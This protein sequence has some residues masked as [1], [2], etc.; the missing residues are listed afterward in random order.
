MLSSVLGLLAPILKNLF[1]KLL[2]ENFIK[3]VAIQAL[4]GAAKSSNN[5]INEELV[6]SVKQAWGK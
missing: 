3:N 1:L 6:E 5:T 4:E 2:T